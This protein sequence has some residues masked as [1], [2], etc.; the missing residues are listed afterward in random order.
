MLPTH[1]RAH[2][3]ARTRPRKVTY[4]SKQAEHCRQSILGRDCPC[5]LCPVRNLVRCASFLTVLG[6]HCISRSFPLPPQCMLASLAAVT[7][8]AGPAPHAHP[9][10]SHAH[11]VSSKLPRNQTPHAY[12][13][14]CVG[15]P[16]V[17]R[18]PPPSHAGRGEYSGSVLLSDVPPPLREAQTPVSAGRCRPRVRA[19]A[20][21]DAAR[22]SAPPQHALPIGYDVF[23]SAK[24]RA[25]LCISG[26]GRRSAA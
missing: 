17:V 1:E 8:V 11:P 5:R 14:F 15:V 26:A 20:R 12:A 23:F 2:T 9:V 13:A 25:A 4:S 6:I 7:V 24:P 19:P 22:R 18:C 21:N 3:H 10:A 16:A